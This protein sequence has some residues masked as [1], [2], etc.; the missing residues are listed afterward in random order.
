MNLSHSL[1][2]L[3]KTKETKTKK[4]QDLTLNRKKKTLQ[5]Q[6]LVKKNI[7]KSKKKRKKK[8]LKKELFKED[9]NRLSLLWLVDQRDSLMKPKVII[10]MLHYRQTMHSIN[11]WN[12]KKGSKSKM[13]RKSRVNSILGPIRKMSLKSRQVC[14]EV[15]RIKKQTK[16]RLI[17]LFSEEISIMFLIRS[18]NLKSQ[19][20]LMLPKPKRMKKSKGKRNQKSSK[21]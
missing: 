4:E 15:N 16:S 21:K 13:N 18:R 7:R 10:T 1:K 9:N 20:S 3:C 12:W 19:D 11:I 8:R 2:E 14:L 17:M 6:I 5:L